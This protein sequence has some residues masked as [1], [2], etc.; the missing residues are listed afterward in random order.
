M[1]LR[2]AGREMDRHC[3]VGLIGYIGFCALSLLGYRTP[4]GNIVTPWLA[5]ALAGVAFLC[6]GAGSFIAPL[7]P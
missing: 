5:H 2:D 1:Y 6:F 3:L 4:L 7:Q